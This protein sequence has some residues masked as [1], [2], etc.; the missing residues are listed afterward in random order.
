[1]FRLFWREL[2]FRRNA[3]IAW[4]LG[5]CFFPLVYVGIYPSVAEEMAALADLAIYQALGISLGTFADWIGSI[6]LVILPL[7]A[8]IHA[9]LD[10]TATLGSE[11][12]DGRLEMIVALP[13]A[14][15]QIVLAKALAFTV[16]S[17]AIYTFVSLVSLGVFSAIESQIETELSAGQLFVAVL[18]GWPL[19]FAVGMLGLFLA[20]FCPRRRYASIISGVILIVGYMGNNLA[21][22]T[23]LI[24]P[25]EPLFLFS[26]LDA[27]GTGV[28]EGQ[29]AGD[30]LTLLA[31]G[32][33]S[34][35]LAV[36]FFE[37]RNLTVGLWPWQRAEVV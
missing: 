16:T 12:E 9:F 27:T 22:S 6:L 7:V 23:E 36:V 21:A 13:L 32:V 26:Y 11:E 1:M 14:R 24:E 10:T 8:A 29:A 17:A 37:R 20:A 25:F 33:V 3:L 30:V 31:I 18:S 15:W 34:L 5:L 19:V 35:G 2:R 4:G 28:L